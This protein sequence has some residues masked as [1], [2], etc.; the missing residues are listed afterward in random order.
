M[1]TYT[2]HSEQTEL[3]MQIMCALRGTVTRH[4]AAGMVAGDKWTQPHPG[5]WL[6]TQYK[7]D[8]RKFSAF[9]AGPQNPWLPLADWY[10]FFQRKQTFPGKAAGLVKN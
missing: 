1:H 5:H 4:T 9:Y 6:H 7:G 3:E 2:A 10:P 8:T